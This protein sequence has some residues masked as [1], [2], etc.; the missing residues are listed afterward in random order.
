[1]PKLKGKI[2]NSSEREVIKSVILN[3]QFKAKN[4]GQKIEEVLGRQFSHCWDMD[5]VNILDNV[6]KTS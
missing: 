6:G 5:D 1:M 2:L 4:K 3:V